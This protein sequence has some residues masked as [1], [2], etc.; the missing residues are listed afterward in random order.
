[1]PNGTNAWIL[2]SLAGLFASGLPCVASGQASFGDP[3]AGRELALRRCSVC[4]NLEGQRSRVTR[5]APSFIEMAAMRS[6]T[7]VNL[8]VYLRLQH[9]P[10]LMLRGRGVDDL[11]AYIL[12]LRGPGT[13]PALPPQ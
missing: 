1:M 12:S 2:I 8:R 10:E 5:S 13:V 11:V 9:V 3:G 6:R 4:H 7:D